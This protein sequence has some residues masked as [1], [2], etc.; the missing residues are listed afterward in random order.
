[1]PEGNKADQADADGDE[2]ENECPLGE[3]AEMDPVPVIEPDTL[4]RADKER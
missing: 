1:M 4:G 2:D 3:C